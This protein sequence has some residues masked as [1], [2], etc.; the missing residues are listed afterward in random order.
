ML[1]LNNFKVLYECSLLNIE[2]KKLLTL[3]TYNNKIKFNLKN[4]KKFELDFD[5]NFE[6]EEDMS[7]EY[8]EEWEKYWLYSIIYNSE[9]NTEEEQF[10]FD[11]APDDI[12]EIGCISG[13]ILVVIIYCF[14]AERLEFEEDWN[15]YD[16]YYLK[17]P[18]N[19]S[20]CKKNY[21][22][23]RICFF[24]QSSITFNRNRQ[25]KK[26]EWFFNF[27]NFTNFLKNVNRELFS[28]LKIPK[29]NTYTWY[30]KKKKKKSVDRTVN[31]L[32]KRLLSQQKL[33]AS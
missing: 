22:K 15:E 20:I 11:N 24:S 13:E 6:E 21:Y 28:K 27:S 31:K 14:E 9:D 5:Y 4:L 1:N 23:S 18:R 7:D 26:T 12:K 32:I 2:N 19:R 3:I 8:A 16:V 25:T 29:K 17:N 33:N 30:M 10:L